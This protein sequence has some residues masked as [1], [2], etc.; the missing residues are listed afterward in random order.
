MPVWDVFGRNKGKKPQKDEAPQGEKK[1]EEEYQHEPTEPPV[2]LFSTAGEHG[3]KTLAESD[4]DTVDIVFVHGLTGNRETTWTYN[5]TLYWPRDLLTK[6]LPYARILAFGYDA[7]VIRVLNT[8]GSNTI[9]DHGKSLA[10]D[11]SMRR[12]RTQ[13]SDRPIIFVAH[14]LGGLVV[15]QAML[16]A[17]GSSQLYV[18]SLLPSTIAI[19]FIG[20]PH[21]G[22]SK[23]DWARPITRL[24]NLLRKTNKEI[25]AVLSPGSE[26]LANLQQE[27]H[28][29]IEDRRRNDGMWIDIFCFYEELS[30]PGIGDIVPRQS[31]ILPDYPNASIHQ[32][33]SEM[34]KFSGEMDAGYI[35][36]RDQLWLWADAVPKKK[37]EVAA[38]P[39]QSQIQSEDEPEPNSAPEEVD[40]SQPREEDTRKTPQN[41][42]RAVSSGGGAVFIGNVNAGRDFTYNTR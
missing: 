4:Q 37:P 30:Y 40:A 28:T 22:S 41:E 2:P 1:P 26:M 21:L 7:D 14:S 31:A 35:R 36:V 38:A 19:A 39:V 6:E 29:M 32:N 3:L 15:E 12:I 24:S 11:L 23:A 13:S 16:I 27:F 25:V 9:R 8:A 42:R 17:R 18:K 5:K 33:H 20:T 10:Q 34:T